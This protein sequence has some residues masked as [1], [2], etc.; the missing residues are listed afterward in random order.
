MS[1]L[2]KKEKFLLKLSTF[3]TAIGGILII[4]AMPVGS[5]SIEVY[6]QAAASILI[7]I[8]GV[9]LFISSMSTNL[10]STRF[11]K[12]IGYYATL[13]TIVLS[14]I[15][16]AYGYINLSAA[17]TGVLDLIS[18]DVML[19]ALTVMS[20]VSGILNNFFYK[21]IKGGTYGSYAGISL[22]FAGILMPVS[23]FLGLFMIGLACFFFS[24][25]FSYFAKH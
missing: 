14:F 20:I 4:I 12:R 1:I 15:L 18:S 16:M 25:C 21:E 11:E 7:I 17:L 6:L 13:S 23:V 10:I 2:L 24:G 9:F 5:L 22:I 8:S 3:L 19:I